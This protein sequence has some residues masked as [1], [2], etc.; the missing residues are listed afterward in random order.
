[1]R[2]YIFLYE[3]FIKET[4]IIGPVTFQ[5]YDN[6]IDY[7]LKWHNE[8]YRKFSKQPY[9]YHPARVAKTIEE[10]TRDNELV[11]AAFFH[12]ILEDTPENFKNMERQFG[13]RVARIVQELT[14]H[15]PSHRKNIKASFLIKKMLK[16]S[17]D[18][19]TIKLADRLDNISDIIDE[20]VPEKNKSKMWAETTSIIKNLEKL[21]NLKG[22]HMILIDK[23]KKYL[24]SYQGIKNESEIKI[25]NSVE[26][27]NED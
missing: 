11:L 5:G 14:S 18:A 24:N 9:A 7:M 19:L 16:M 21:R 4:R 15:I 12:D 25:F 17:D 23:I 13:K 26:E 3:N 2:K 1:M 6:A 20:N 27:I 8:Q 22:I 10:Y